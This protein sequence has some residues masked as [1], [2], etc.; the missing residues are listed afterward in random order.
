MEGASQSTGKGQSIGV[1]IDLGFYWGWMSLTFFSTALIGEGSINIIEVSNLIALVLSTLT[2]GIVA[3]LSVPLGAQIAQ[4]SAIR[5]I[6]TLSASAG[7]FLMFG[8]SS[9]DGMSIAG[10]CLIGVPEG[11]LLYLFVYRAVRLCQS[12]EEVVILFSQALLIAS[13]LYLMALPLGD[14]AGVFCALL[15]LASLLG[16]VVARSPMGR[17]S[18]L[19]RGNGRSF[20]E[21]SRK[22]PWKLLLGLAVFGMA[23]GLMR[24]STTAESLEVFRW[25]YVAHT[26]SRAA[27]AALAILLVGKMKKAY[28]TLSTVQLLA[29]TVGICSYWMPLESTAILTIAATTV[30]YTCLEL[31]LWA[32]LFELY[33]ETDIAFNIL[34]GATRGLVSLATLVATAFALFFMGSMTSATVHVVLLFFLLAMILVSSLLFGSRNVASLWGLERPAIDGSQSGVEQTSR[35]L[36]DRF[37]LTAREAEVLTL[38]MRGRNE[39]FIS[40]ALFISPSTTHSHVTHI[41]AKLGVHS[42]QELLDVAEKLSLPA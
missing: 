14:A 33:R 23:F 8:A 29:F 27:V 32:V 38:L 3:F 6:A 39:P 25:S 24:I 30:G 37:N 28:W 26:L 19:A 7:T 13:G 40:E 21:N 4:S 22:L 11:L 18:L 12:A 20:W 5:L 9:F 16:L 31:L 10:S 41:Y 36:A 34:Y 35:A 42:R 17:T 2:V 1:A 15:P